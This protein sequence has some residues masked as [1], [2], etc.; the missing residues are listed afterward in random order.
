MKNSKIQSLFGL[1]SF[2]APTMPFYGS[3]VAVHHHE[4]SAAVSKFSTRGGSIT[5]KIISF[6]YTHI[7]NAYVKKH[8]TLGKK[9][10]ISIER[11]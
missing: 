6:S 4:G 2:P 3:E 8:N 5:T 11:R 10:I 7:C 1:T 9:R